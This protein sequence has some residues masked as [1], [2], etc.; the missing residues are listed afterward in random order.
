MLNLLKNAKHLAPYEKVRVE[1]IVESLNCFQQI[2]Q[3]KLSLLT[4]QHPSTTI[5]MWKRKTLWKTQVDILLFYYEVFAHICLRLLSRNW[6]AGACPPFDC[7]CIP[8][9]RL[10]VHTRRLATIRRF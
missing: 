3:A 2:K 8:T 9:I 5:P 10:R 7:G 1:N 6:L 4:Y